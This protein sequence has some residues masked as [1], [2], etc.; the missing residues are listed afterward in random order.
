MLPGARAGPWGQRGEV[1]TP[2]GGFP[3]WRTVP[4]LGVSP[5]P[6]ASAMP[7]MPPALRPPP[8]VIGLLDVFTPDETLD[9]FTDL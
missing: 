6:A 3:A 9:D 7:P 2:A 8:Q 1:G 5:S 4:A